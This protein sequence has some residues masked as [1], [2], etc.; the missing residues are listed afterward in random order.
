MKK[1]L[2]V[3]FLVLI[4]APSVANDRFTQMDANSDGFIVWEEFSAAMPN[5]KQRAFETIDTD[6][7]GRLSRTEWSQFSSQHGMKKNGSIMPGM[8]PD[9]TGDKPAAPARKPLVTPPKS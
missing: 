3:L 6:R 1:F 5:M 8:H 4:A 2:F 7:D 9:G